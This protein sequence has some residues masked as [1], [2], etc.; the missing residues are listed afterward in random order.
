VSVG[1][2]GTGLGG[3]FFIISAL[4]ML[5][6]ELVRLAL[7]RSS[8]SRV[9]LAARHAGIATAMV[10]VLMGSYWVLRFGVRALHE[11]STPRGL[12]QLLP[13]APV[14]F[15]LGVLVTV[16]TVSFVARVA[17]HPRR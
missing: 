11:S 8:L 15:T 7:G 13:V 9:G 12:A 17:L 6:I 4:L 3:L 5:P 2:P 14:L 16:L 1:L 10:A